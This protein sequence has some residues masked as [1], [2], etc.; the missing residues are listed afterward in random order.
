MLVTCAPPQATGS[1]AVLKHMRELCL[2]YTA[3]W[4]GCRISK[5]QSEG[6][7][8]LIHRPN[9]RTEGNLYSVIFRRRWM[10]WRRSAP[11]SYLKSNKR[12]MMK[13][14]QSNIMADQW[15]SGIVT[16][17]RPIDTWHVSLLRAYDK[18]IARRTSK[19]LNP[20]LSLT[21]QEHR[22]Q[23]TNMAS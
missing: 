18:I 4:K 22:S 23:M 19:P 11:P 12:I 17:V 10:A 14:K 7:S 13:K 3:G 16:A 9:E 20:S 15:M 5:G 6:V 1:A 2:H 21:G 8:R